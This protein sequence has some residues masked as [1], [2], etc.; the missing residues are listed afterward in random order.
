MDRRIALK[1]IGLS[2]GYIVA[3]PTLLSI[4]QSCNDTNV[5]DWT[6]DF[7]TKGEGNVLLKLVDIILPKT[8]TPSASE[9][10][11]HVFIDKF[12]NEIMEVEQQ[13]FLKMSMSKFINKALK[14]AGKEKAEDLTTEDLEPVLAAA[15]KVSKDDEVA[16]FKSINTYNEAIKNGETAELDDAISRF[17]FANNLRGMTIWGYKSSEYVGEN[18]LAYLPIPGEYVGCGDLQELTKGKAWSI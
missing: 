5:V 1:N 7:L 12:T 14:D 8:D 13:N 15:L 4:V 6:P 17:A 18:V 10:N 2:L 11:V 9:V 16:N 3:T